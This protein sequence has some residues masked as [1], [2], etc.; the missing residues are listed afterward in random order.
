MSGGQTASVTNVTPVSPSST[1]SGTVET[2]S[3]IISGRSRD[4]DLFDVTGM[5]EEEHT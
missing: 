1:S 2:S 5:S 3:F 4:H